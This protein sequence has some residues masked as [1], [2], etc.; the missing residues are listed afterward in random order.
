MLVQILR[1]F[2]GNPAAKV[3]PSKIPS[4]TRQNFSHV[5]DE[6]KHEGDE[7]KGDPNPDEEPGDYPGDS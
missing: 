6:R 5:V 3:S 4:S 7:R 2:Y 1:A